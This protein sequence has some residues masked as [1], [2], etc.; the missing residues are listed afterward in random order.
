MAL[1]GLSAGLWGFG[2]V[3]TKG[4]LQG[5]APEFIS[6]FRLTLAALL[7]RVLAGEGA[8]WFVADIW[9]WVAGVALG[10][11]FILYNYGIQHTSANV[12]ALVINVEL[13]STIG[14]AVWLLGERLSRRRVLGSAVTLSGVLL[15]GLNGVRLSDVLPG[16]QT[17]GNM[18]VMAAG[19]SWSLFAVAQRRARGG[20]RL[21]HRLTPIFSVAALTTLPL[22]LHRSAWM[23]TGGV[24]PTVMLVA[25]AILCT[26]LVYLV[27]GRA[28][29]FLD[30]SV[31]AILLCS[32]P[33][34]AV[35]FA[36]V[37][38][39]EPVTQRLLLGGGVIVAG[40]A[41]IAAE[42]GVAPE[43]AP[44]LANQRRARPQPTESGLTHRA[45]RETSST[46]DGPVVTAG[47]EFGS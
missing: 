7:F 19:I 40:I 22:L 45:I 46:H 6:V 9:V 29:E 11:D 10:A 13:V 33:V 34:F 37:L 47:R 25:L 1:A 23:M 2:P 15:V 20:H 21:F 41:I 36:Y 44:Q 32:I 3:A 5:F 14:F 8:Q 4:A 27:Y 28:Q 35:V 24:R 38:L 43:A 12:A 18:L 31:L 30:V 26:G 39:G 42:Q 16:G 17:V